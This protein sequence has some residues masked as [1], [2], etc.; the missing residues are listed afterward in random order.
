MIERQ[1]D[2]YNVETFFHLNRY[3]TRKKILTTDWTTWAR[4]PI[5]AKDFS[6]SFCV[7]IGSGAH[8]A[9]CLMGTEGPFAGLKRDRDVTL[10]TH[11]I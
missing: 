10:T 8:P 9:S 11:P 3:I 6:S 7:Q 2:V 5:E 1:D 4:L